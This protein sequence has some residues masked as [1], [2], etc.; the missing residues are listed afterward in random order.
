M[1]FAEIVQAV[2]GGVG[3]AVAAFVARKVSKDS[4]ASK[5]ATTEI[6]AA[7]DA[8]AVRMNEAFLA[9]REHVDERIDDTVERVARIERRLSPPGMPAVRERIPSSSG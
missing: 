1:T 9:H 2:G 8:H 6:K 3:A 5:D 4:T 7:I